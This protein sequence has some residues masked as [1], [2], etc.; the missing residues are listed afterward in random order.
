MMKRLLLILCAV[1]LCAT[2]VAGALRK[3][4][5]EEGARM[6]LHGRS[7]DFGT[8]ERRGGDLTC[9]FG[10]TNDGTAPLVLTRVVTTC[11]CLKVHYSRRPVAPGG[12]GR[13]R[14]VY[15]PQKSEPGVFNKVIQIY[16]NAGEGPEVISVHGNAVDEGN[17]KIKGNKIKIKN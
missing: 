12:E 8:V 17:V 4:A 2:T 1:L 10:F 13:I 6:R 7:H 9:E 3:R 16:S 5:A 15:E 14:I 11:S